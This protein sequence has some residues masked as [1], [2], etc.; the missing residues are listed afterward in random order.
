MKTVLVTGANGF[1]GRHAL[2]PLIEKNYTV[3][4]LYANHHPIYEHPRVYW[5]QVNLHDH[6]AVQKFLQTIQPSHLLHLAWFAKPNEYWTSPA[7]LEWL[8]NSINLLNHFIDIKGKRAVFV[9]SCA[10][11][12]W[13]FQHCHEFKTT[14]APHT[15]YGSAKHALY[16][17]ASSLS[18]LNHLSFA[19][20]RLFYLFGAHEYKE[21][22][23]PSAINHFLKNRVMTVKNKNQQRDFMYV[24]DVAD[25]LVSLLDSS[26]EGP[27]NIASGRVTSLGELIEQI[28]NR[29]DKQSFI[30]Y[31][32]QP[33]HNDILAADITRLQNEVR[34]Q[35]SYTLDRA[36]DETIAWWQRQ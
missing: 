5:H 19:W 1:I 28:A 16:L 20:A 26:V 17:L 34:W 21:R 8:H 13:Q 32:T 22:L 10:E 31:E 15:L 33:I 35:P 3:H 2:N 4:A 18:K 24:G 25:A 23:I 27:V 6:S 9:G 30:Q 7:N 14:C 12:D 11:Y 29:L 36:I